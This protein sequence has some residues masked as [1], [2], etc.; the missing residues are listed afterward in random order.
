M[1]LSTPHI[2]RQLVKPLPSAAHFETVNA[3][4]GPA[5]TIQVA[6]DVALAVTDRNQLGLGAVPGTPTARIAI[7]PFLDV[8][9]FSNQTGTI[10]VEYG[11]AGG[12]YRELAVTAVPANILTNISGL[13]ITARFVRITYTNT[14][15][16]AALVEFGAY[17]RST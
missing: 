3:A 9:A 5:G 7:G 14:A 10:R 15:A 2:P 1:P 16:V 11:V 6:Y 13:R 8:V 12:S 4:L 17:V